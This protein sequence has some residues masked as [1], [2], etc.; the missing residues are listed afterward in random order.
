[1]PRKNTGLDLPR[2]LWRVVVVAETI[3]DLARRGLSAATRTRSP[4]PGRLRCHVNKSEIEF[5]VGRYAVIDFPAYARPRW[6]T[7]GGRW[8]EPSATVHVGDDM[9]LRVA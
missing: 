8:R 6:T 7:T 9:S 2:R 5:S 1:M 3:K 4:A